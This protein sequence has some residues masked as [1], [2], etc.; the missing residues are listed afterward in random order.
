MVASVEV[1]AC[2]AENASASGCCELRDSEKDATCYRK[3][4][5]DSLAAPELSA[6]RLMITGRPNKA[7]STELEIS[8]RTVDRR[9][10]IVQE[11]MRLIPHQNSLGL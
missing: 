9:R 2:F 5:L 7:I 3:P 6:I 11:K 4:R 10:S 8:M 1:D